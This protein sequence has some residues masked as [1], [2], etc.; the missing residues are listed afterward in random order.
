MPTFTRSPRH[1]TLADSGWQTS[2][3][4]CHS[5]TAQRR[6]R[7][8]RGFSKPLIPT[9]LKLQIGLPVSDQENA[10]SSVCSMQAQATA[11]SSCLWIDS[12]GTGLSG[13]RHRSHIS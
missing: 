1:S 2:R 12:V 9:H 13:L 7:G 5:S 3:H 8:A 6:N 4:S 11:S 10:S